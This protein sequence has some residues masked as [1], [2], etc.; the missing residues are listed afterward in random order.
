MALRF[1]KDSLQNR[2]KTTSLFT[3][4]VFSLQEVYRIMSKCQGSLKIII[5]IFVTFAKI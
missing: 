4:E 1:H 2:F 3:L 5:L